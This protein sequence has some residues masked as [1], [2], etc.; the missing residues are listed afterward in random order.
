MWE[1]PRRRNC[2]DVLDGFLW[3]RRIR[4]FERIRLPLL[5]QRSAPY[6][7]NI[8]YIW[9][10]WTLNKL[11]VWRW[12]VS[13]EG[14]AHLSGRHY[15]RSARPNYFLLFSF[16][17]DGQ[18][19]RQHFSSSCQIPPKIKCIFLPW[20]PLGLSLFLCIWSWLPVF[21]TISRK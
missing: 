15:A 6:S 19:Y 12:G 11:M 4:G 18:Q 2:S 5:P 1:K 14:C 16:S 9:D 7:C 3:S 20:L 21:I 13:V 10:P 17:R 8:K